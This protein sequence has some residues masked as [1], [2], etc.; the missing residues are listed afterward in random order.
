MR[1]LKGISFLILGHGRNIFQIS[2]GVTKSIA[3]PED[4]ENCHLCGFPTRQSGNDQSREDF[5][6]SPNSDLLVGSCNA[7][8]AA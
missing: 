5:C 7:T 2:R 4:L 1:V 8:R 3:E 6:F